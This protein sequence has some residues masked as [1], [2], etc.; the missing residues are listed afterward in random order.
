MSNLAAHSSGPLRFLAVALLLASLPHV[1]A[2]PCPSYICLDSLLYPDPA[3]CMFRLNESLVY[4]RNTCRI[5]FL[6]A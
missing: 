6:A 2:G 3:L 1:S 4:V 5:R